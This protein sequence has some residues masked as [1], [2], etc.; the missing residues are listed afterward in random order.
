MKQRNGKDRRSG[1]DRRVYDDNIM[2]PD[3]RGG[4]DRRNKKKWSRPTKQKRV[5][6]I[7]PFRHA[8]PV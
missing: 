6:G 4:I 5:K 8:L 3:G 7:Y 1:N 2:P